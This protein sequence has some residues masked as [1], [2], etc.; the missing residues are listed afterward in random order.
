MQN[1]RLTPGELAPIYHPELG[2]FL[3]AREAAASWNTMRMFLLQ[4][5][6]A[7]GDIYA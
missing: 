3:A 4:R 1:G 7:H 5:Y 2:L 6:G